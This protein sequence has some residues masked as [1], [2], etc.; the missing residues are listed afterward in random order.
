MNSKVS[1]SEWI[2]VGIIVLL[3]VVFYVTMPADKPRIVGL[4]LPVTASLTAASLDNV[5]VYS[6]LPSGVRVISRIHLERHYVS[7]ESAQRI[8]Q[9][10]LAKAKRMA[11]AVGANALVLKVL[12][13]S[14]AG[15]PQLQIYQLQ[16]LAI[17]QG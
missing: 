16:A 1:F 12:G 17:K 2:N 8:E 15:P 3:I 14:L 4:A 13:Y 6:S 9:R 11:A 5:L 10:L 7:G